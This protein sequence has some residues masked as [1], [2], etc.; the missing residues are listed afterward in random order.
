MIFVCALDTNITY[1]V[2]E[3]AVGNHWHAFALV[4][5]HIVSLAFDAFVFPVVE[6]AAMDSWSKGIGETSS[7]ILSISISA[8]DTSIDGSL[9]HS[10][11]IQINGIAPDSAIVYKDFGNTI[12]L[13]VRL[14]E[15]YKKLVVWLALFTL[16]RSLVAWAVINNSRANETVGIKSVTLV[17]IETVGCVGVKVATVLEGSFV[18]GK[19]RIIDKHRSWPITR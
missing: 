4:S 8:N 12:D 13:V 5:H 15:V 2:G 18:F 11:G 7:S 10:D 19:A 14:F 16:V 6:D 3:N 1:W 17:T 9:V